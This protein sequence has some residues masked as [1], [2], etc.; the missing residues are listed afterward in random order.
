MDPRE[1][2][3]PQWWEERLV[4]DY[5]EG[6]PLAAVGGAD[7]PQV[8]KCATFLTSGAIGQRF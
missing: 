2:S 6:V 7:V 3:S 8:R 4:A 1:F 5:R